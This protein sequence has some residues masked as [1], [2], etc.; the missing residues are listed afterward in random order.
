MYSNWQCAVPEK[1]IP[2]IPCI[3]GHSENSERGERLQK[4]FKNF[5]G[6]ERKMHTM[7]N[8]RKNA[9]YEAT[10]KSPVLTTSHKQ[11]K[12]DGISRVE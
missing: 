10:V 11:N 5:R 4:P 9:H 2:N 8:E 12:N 3:E 6:N 7:K 1:P